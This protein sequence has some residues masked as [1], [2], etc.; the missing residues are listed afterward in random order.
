MSLYS[1]ILARLSPGDPTSPVTSQVEAPQ[2]PNTPVIQEWESG[3]ESSYLHLSDIIAPSY[4]N[5]PAPFLTS[6]H[7]TV[8]R[9]IHVSTNTI[10]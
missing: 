2:S 5:N 1:L 4:M 7:K 10:Y 9:S 8:S 6:L 3:L